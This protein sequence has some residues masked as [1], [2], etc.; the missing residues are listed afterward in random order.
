[1]QWLKRFINTGEALPTICHPEP[2]LHTTH[3]FLETSLIFSYNRVWGLGD[4]VL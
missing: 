3:I 1:M 2:K 4:A